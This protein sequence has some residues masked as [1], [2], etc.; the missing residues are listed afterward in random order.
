VAVSRTRAAPS[1]PMGPEVRVQRPQKRAGLVT[2]TQPVPSTAKSKP[3]SV[4]S[5]FAF[6][7]LAPHAVALA[8]KGWLPSA[9]R[10]A[11]FCDVFRR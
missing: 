3:L 5:G 2:Q 11:L 10:I 8:S 4:F 7:S 6:A 1:A 9:R